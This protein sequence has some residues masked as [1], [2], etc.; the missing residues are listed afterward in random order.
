MLTIRHD[1]LD[2]VAAMPGLLASVRAVSRLPG[3]TVGLERVLG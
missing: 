1:M 3:L 2:R